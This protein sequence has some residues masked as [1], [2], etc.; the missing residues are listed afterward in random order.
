MIGAARPIER[1]TW[2]FV[3]DA[4]RPA[5]VPSGSLLTVFRARFEELRQTAA[6]RGAV[7]FRG[8]DLCDRATF[9]DF[10]QQAVQPLDYVYGNSPRSRLTEAVYTSSEFPPEFS[11]SFHNELSYCA[12]W[13][14][15]LLFFCALAAA[16]GGETPLVDSHALW[17]ALPRHLRE[18]FEKRGLLYIR[19][20]HGG[21]GLGPSWATTFG[22]SERA[23]VESLC[24]AGDIRFEWKDDG[25]LRI[26][27]LRPATQ[28][29][30]DTGE[31][32]W[33]NQADQF[34]P[35]NH[36]AVVGDA[37]AQYY[38]GREED[39]PHYCLHGDRTPLDPTDLEVV[40]R[41]AKSLARAFS[42]QRGDLLLVDNMKAAHGRN[43]YRGAREI[44][45]SMF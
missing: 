11:I 2:P 21:K 15:Y 8:F 26:W 32:L 4:E 35:T 40:R 36:P 43:P 20:L 17:Q 24:E 16:E 23:R 14:R 19:N 10:V 30:P 9:H 33:F 44:L 7:L 6:E 31:P 25:S 27:E 29:H 41:T 22:T 42:W 34:H 12:S 45:V 38:R 13:P 18:R 37:L 39:M 1:E 3:V 28:L 5:P